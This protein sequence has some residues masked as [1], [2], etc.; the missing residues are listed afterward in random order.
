MDNSVIL[1]NYS[2]D[3][4]A[5]PLAAW[6]STGVSMQDLELIPVESRLNFIFEQV[7]N[8]KAHS[9]EALVEFLATEGHTSP[10]RHIHLMYGITSEIASHIQFLKHRVGVDINSESAR[11]KR[12]KDTYYIPSDLPPS[13]QAKIESHN[14]ACHDLYCEIYDQLIE[15]GFSKAR[16]KESSRFV[17]PYS[18]QISY[19][20]T[21]SLQALAHFYQLRSSKHAQL[22]IRQIA[23][24]MLSQLV[25]TGKFD[26]VIPFILGE[27]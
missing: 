13:V 19:I 20:V 18:K 27:N 21:L 1:L 23:E 16:A 10:F 3:W 6:A 12:L 15:A 8:S 7:K 22:E 5:V 11:Y 24:A 25:D 2:F 9:A 26:P 4:R 17:L 14:R